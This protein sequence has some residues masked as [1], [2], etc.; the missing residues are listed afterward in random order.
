MW[1]AVTR[2]PWLD[3]HLIAD[4]DVEVDGLTA[5]ALGHELQ[6]V[7]LSTMEGVGS[8]RTCEDFIGVVAERAQQDGRR[9]LAAAVDAHEHVVLGIELEVEPGAAVGDD[10]RREQQLAR[11]MGLALVVI[12]EHAGRAVQLGD[13]DALGAVDDEG[14]GLGHQR[15]SPM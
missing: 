14:A 11:R 15:Q 7:R 6:L 5:Q 3:H 10:P 8:R 12:E 13:D 4:L 9:Q 1:R 2:R